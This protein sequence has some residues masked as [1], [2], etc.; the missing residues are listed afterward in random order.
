MHKHN[1]VSQPTTAVYEERENSISSNIQ[2]QNTLN[3]QSI[4]EGGFF[5]VCVCVCVCVFFW[6]AG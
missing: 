4:H 1:M 3:G 6:G 2:F 5:C